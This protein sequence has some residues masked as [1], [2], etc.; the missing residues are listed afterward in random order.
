MEL[1]AG[2]SFTTGPKVKLARGA[3]A[4]TPVPCLVP[5]WGDPL[6][7]AQT[8]LDFDAIGTELNGFNGC[9]GDSEGLR[10][11][12]R[13]GE[14]CDG[15][16]MPGPRHLLSRDRRVVPR[17]PQGRSGRRQ[18]RLAAMPAAELQET[19]RI[20]PNAHHSMPEDG[21]RPCSGLDPPK[22][23]VGAPWMTTPITKDGLTPSALPR[24]RCPRR[25]GAAAR[26]PAR[27][28]VYVLTYPLPRQIE[29]AGS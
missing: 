3:R 12:G 10:K 28:R 25:R 27:G 23:K 8:A 1:A 17:A 6:R 13:P 29:E 15:G 14:G 2:S 20:P 4:T 5:G 24:T 22:I 19:G 7:P 9:H 16:G 11:L 21:C 18:M 26:G